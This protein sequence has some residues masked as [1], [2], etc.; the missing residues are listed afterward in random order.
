MSEKLLLCCWDC[1]EL[2][3]RVA[4][5]LKT[6]RKEVKEQG[7]GRGAIGKDEGEGRKEKTQEKLEQRS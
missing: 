2:S 5:Q 3:G 7:K 6:G 1:S 4:L